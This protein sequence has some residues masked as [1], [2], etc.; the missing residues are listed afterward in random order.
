MGA[1]EAESRGPLQGTREVLFSLPITARK[2][3]AMLVVSK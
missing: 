2:F 1:G 3:V